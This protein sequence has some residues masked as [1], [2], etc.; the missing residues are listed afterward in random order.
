MEKFDN[1][2]LVEFL[3]ER[4]ML[5]VSNVRRLFSLLRCIPCFSILCNI[6]MLHRTRES[7]YWVGNEPDFVCQLRAWG[8]VGSSKAKHAEKLIWRQNCRF[9]PSS[10][11]LSIESFLFRFSELRREWGNIALIINYNM[12]WWESPRLE[13]SF[14]DEDYSNSL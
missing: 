2:M 12:C 7:L 11:R 9:G 6:Q 4:G 3:P 14:L 5:E 8:T 10:L 1:W 13:L